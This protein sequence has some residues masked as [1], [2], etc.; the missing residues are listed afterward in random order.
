MSVSKKALVTLFAGDNTASNAT[1][2][3]GYT[4]TITVVDYSALAGKSITIN[5][6]TYTEDGGVAGWDTTTGG[7]TNATTATSIGDI[8]T[9]DTS[10]TPTVL[11][12]VVTVI[13]AGGGILPVPTSSDP[14]NL[15]VS[16][17]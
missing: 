14:I 13:K 11:T 9:N 3:V 6:I 1:S 12:N 7:N 16:N 15:T 4:I 17:V 10:I 5:G 8:L 2:P